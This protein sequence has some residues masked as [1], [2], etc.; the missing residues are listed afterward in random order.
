MSTPVSPASLSPVPGP[1]FDLLDSR[2]Q[3]QYEEE[4]VIMELA[5]IM[6]SYCQHSVNNCTSQWLLKC[7]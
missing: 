6:K 7:V 3:V 1:E 2:G 5:R 4:D